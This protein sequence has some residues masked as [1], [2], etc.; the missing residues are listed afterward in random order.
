M[1][2]MNDLEDDGFNIFAAS[3]MFRNG[4]SV[5]KSFIAIYKGRR[6]HGWFSETTQQYELDYD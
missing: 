5:V 2:T 6:T 3:F 1:R 4:E